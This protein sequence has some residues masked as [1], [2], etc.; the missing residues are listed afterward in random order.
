MVARRLTYQT[1]RGAA[2]MLQETGRSP[3]ELR[4]QVSSPGGTTLAGLAALDDRGFVE[5]VAGA[6][7]AATRRSRELGR[8]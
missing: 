4:A 1:L 3:E 8:G 5:T 2:M 6:V 7:A